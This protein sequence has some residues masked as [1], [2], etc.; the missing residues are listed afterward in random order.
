MALWS[1]FAEPVY[2]SVVSIKGGVKVVGQTSYYKR[3]EQ[4][5]VGGCKDV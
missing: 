5:R 3:S 4:P 2:T 1:L